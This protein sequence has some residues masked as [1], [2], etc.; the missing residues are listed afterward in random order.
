MTS[1]TLPRRY[2]LLAPW[3]FRVF[4]LR[5]GDALFVV[6]KSVKNHPLTIKT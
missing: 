3:A 5:I 1:H 6:R 2:V 4:S